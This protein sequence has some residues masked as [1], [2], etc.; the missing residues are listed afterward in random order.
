[1]CQVTIMHRRPKILKMIHS[2]GFLVYEYTTV[3][4]LRPRGLKGSSK[5]V[6]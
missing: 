3:K 4:G 1:M 2:A 6:N 5:G